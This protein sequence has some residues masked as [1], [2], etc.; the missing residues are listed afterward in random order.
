MIFIWKF[1]KLRSP[2]QMFPSKINDKHRSSR[3]CGVIGIRPS[4]FNTVVWLSFYNVAGV[5]RRARALYDWSH[6]GSVF[7]FSFSV[8]FHSLLSQWAVGRKIKYDGEICTHG[9]SWP[10]RDGTK[11]RKRDFDRFIKFYDVDRHVDAADDA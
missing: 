7:P 8:V 4:L 3:V 2:R 5:K 6:R 11:A 9:T 10:R 1:T